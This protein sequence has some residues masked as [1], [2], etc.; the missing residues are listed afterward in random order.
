MVWGFVL[1][2]DDGCSS[3]ARVWRDDPHAWQWDAIGWISVGGLACAALLLVAVLI[4]HIRLASVA[5]VMW[6]ALG[7]GYLALLEESNRGSPDVEAWVGFSLLVCVG[8]LSVALTAKGKQKSS[9]T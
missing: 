9:P 6:A 7:C 8:I 3:P 1:K 5:V 2:C 4:A